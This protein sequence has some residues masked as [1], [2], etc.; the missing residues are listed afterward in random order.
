LTTNLWTSSNQTPF[1]VVVEFVA[2]W[3]R[4]QWWQEKWEEGQEGWKTP[5]GKGL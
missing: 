5:V 1:M 3:L 4:R 2:K